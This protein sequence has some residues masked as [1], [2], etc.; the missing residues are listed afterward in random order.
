MRYTVKKEQSK[1][2]PWKVVLDDG[3]AV[4]RLTRKYRAEAEAELLNA[5]SEKG[6]P[7]AREVAPRW[8]RACIRC[9]GVESAKYDAQLKGMLPGDVNAD[10]EGNPL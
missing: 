4:A 7:R 2:R 1:P 9:E 3:V 10:E 6:Q 8:Y 5:L